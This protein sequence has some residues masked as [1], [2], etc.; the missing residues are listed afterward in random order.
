MQDVVAG[1]RRRAVT[2]DQAERIKRDRRIAD[3]GDVVLDGEEI[4]VVD[5]NGALERQALAVVPAQRHR[6][7]CRQRACA[8]L[9]P[10]G[11]AARHLD[12]RTCRRHE[13]ELGVERLL[14]ARRREQFNRRGFRIDGLAVF[15]QRD[16]VDARAGQRDAA[17]DVGRVDL[18]A[19]A[20][21]NRGGAA[22]DRRSGGWRC[23]CTG[24]LAGSGGRR[25]VRARRSGRGRR[26]T[27]G[28]LLRQFGLLRGALLFHLRNVVEVLP[29]DQHK[30]R[31]DD[32]E[33]GIAIFDHR[34]GLV[35]RS[36]V[37]GKDCVWLQVAGGRGVWRS[38][39]LSAERRSLNMVSKPRS[40]AARRP[41][42]T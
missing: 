22:L 3:V 26:R 13:T 1:D 37:F 7:C 20:G 31:Q 36:G 2:R 11:V 25:L 40:S 14:G 30:A 32:G 42:I 41:T 21:C 28:L 4:L 9:R 34:S 19:R 12:G 15:H 17:A 6:R 5:R 35:M 27:G 16:V 23:R 18:H 33:D 39:R 8:F 10:D 24:L 38:R 29:C